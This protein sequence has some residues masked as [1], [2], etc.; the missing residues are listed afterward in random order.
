MHKMRNFQQS[1]ISIASDQQDEQFSCITD[2]KTR[3]S[4]RWS[5]SQQ[6]SGKPKTIECQPLCKRFFTSSFWC[7]LNW[8]YLCKALKTELNMT[9]TKDQNFVSLSLNNVESTWWVHSPLS[10][11]SQPGLK[12][13]VDSKIHF[14]LHRFAFWHRFLLSRWSAL[15]MVPQKFSC[16]SAAAVCVCR[17]LLC[18]GCNPRLRQTLQVVEP[19]T[20]LSLRP[21]SARWWSNWRP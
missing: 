7:N 11:V 5:I 17:L 15:R 10:S 16:L 12:S 1:A 3:G 21:G 6:R 13:S 20:L 18:R 8:L 19:R 2:L 4:E 14:F 9:E